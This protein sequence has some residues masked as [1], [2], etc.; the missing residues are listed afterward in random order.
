MERAYM[1]KETG[2]VSCCWSAPNRE[3]VANLFKKA[4]VVFEAI[5]QV[6]EAAEK[7]FV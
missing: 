7:D 5:T 6:E 1:D 4:G 2:R 3:K